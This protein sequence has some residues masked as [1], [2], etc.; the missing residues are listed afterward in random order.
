MKLKI[1][2]AL[3]LLSAAIL[4][5]QTPSNSTL[6]ATRSSN[7]SLP[8]TRAGSAS[9]PYR[10]A[11]VSSTQ[12]RQAALPVQ[13]GTKAS[14]ATLV[15]NVFTDTDLR[16]ALQDV[17]TQIGVTII[18]DQS[19]AGVVSCEMKDVPLDKAL[20]ILL[21]GTGYSVL[22]TEDY[23]LVYS[24]DVK[25]P[26]F[27]KV[28]MTEVIKL[29]YVDAEMALKMLSPTYRDF[30]QAEPKGSKL[31]VTAPESLLVRICQDIRRID[32]APRHVMLEA[33][34]VVFEKVDLLNLGVKWNWPSLRAGTFTDNTL[35]GTRWPWMVDIG[36]AP[37]R[38]FTNS[39][40]VTL[41]LLSENDDV[42]ILSRPQLMAQDGKEAEVAVTTDEYFQIQSN[43]IY[44][45][46]S[47]LEKIQS[48]TTLKMT[49][50]IGANGDITL[51]LSIEVSDVAARG[52]NNLP[53]VSRRV[54]KSTVRVKSGGTAAIAG[55]KA[56]RSEKNKTKTPG[57][58]EVPGVGELFTDR[59]NRKN[60]LQV[61]VF[62][63]ATIATPDEPQE[64]L[65]TRSAQTP[66][67]VDEGEFRTA[68]KQSLAK[69][70][71]K[72]K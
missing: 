43:S 42:M 35:N 52:E 56:V 61:A 26:L 3:V 33:R 14:K 9:L 2:G 58:S 16:Q 59:A 69:L 48:G 68:L 30:V 44:V 46:N 70:D 54:A 6:P 24:S 62:V 50:R 41:D 72:D 11:S 8:T 22:R 39:L 32:Q 12:P 45:S 18:T 66:V 55:L 65:A 49:P 13:A 27:S 10:S 40:L 15:S 7:S 34:V 17:A 71:G 21:A 31:V 23:Y 64:P 53:V 47:T 36:L 60:S 38:T 57:I 51:D 29:D 1:A 20:D 67:A 37:D 28:S 63:T 25:S 4:V 5:A 19:V